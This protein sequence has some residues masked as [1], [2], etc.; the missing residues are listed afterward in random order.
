[1][2]INYDLIKKNVKHTFVSRVRN[3]Y[4]YIPINLIFYFLVSKYSMYDI[5]MA[6]KI[7]QLKKQDQLWF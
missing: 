4:Q 3:S 2:H 1:M 7:I 5:K 6:V